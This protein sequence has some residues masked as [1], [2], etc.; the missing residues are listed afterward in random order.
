MYYHLL[1][2]HNVGCNIVIIGTLQNEEEMLVAVAVAVAVALSNLP[3]IPSA[4]LLL[5]MSTDKS[6]FKSSSFMDS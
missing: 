3:D 5:V 1:D 4:P 2:R 6:N